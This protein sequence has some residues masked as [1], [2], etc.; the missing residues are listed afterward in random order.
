MNTELLSWPSPTTDPVIPAPQRRAHRAAAAIVITAVALAFADASVVALAIPD[1]YIEFEASIPAVSWVLTG[2]A[3]AVAVA[4]LAL[5]GILRRVTAASLTIVGGFVFAAASLWASL[6]PD[7]GWLIAARVVQGIGGAALIAGALGVLTTLL[8]DARRAARWWAT[9]GIAGAVLGPAVGGAVTQLLDWRAVFVVQAPIAFLAA[10]AA[11]RVRRE[12]TVLHVEHERRPGSAMVADTALGLTFGALVGVLFLGVLLLVVV[13]G[14]PPMAGALV[15]SALPVGTLLA[16]R[17]AQLVAPKAAVVAGAAL[18]AG[19]LLTIAYVPAIEPAWVAA[20]MLLC[21]FGLGMVLHALNPHALPHGSGVRAATLTSTARH[22]GLVVGLALIA[23]VL[24]SQLLDAA[25]VAPLPATKV[26]LDAPIDGP[27]KIRIALDIRDVLDAASK[28][29]VPDLGPVFAENGADDPQVAQLQTDIEEGVQGVITRAFSDS[30]ALAAA[31]AALGG[32]VGVIAISLSSSAAGAPR[33]RGATAVVLG[34]ALA[35]AVLL[36][37]AAVQAASPD[38]GSSAVA[39]PCTAGPDPFPGD[40]LDA[41]IQRLVLSGLNGAA[42]DLGVSR[43]ELVLSLEPRSGVDVKWDRD[44]IAR[45]LEQGVDRAISDAQDRG[46]LPGWVAAAV[47][48]TVD[49][50]PTSWFLEQLGVG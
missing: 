40:G 43:E 2:Y 4:G 33:R 18:L 37:A 23:P 35:A 22:L 47:R 44:T 8:G 15:V 45:A 34:G 42:C 38:F 14:M 1:L 20:A 9:G 13:W 28:G 17:L 11:I 26:M 39:D 6:A 27:T 49:R 50:V 29:E 25:E 30:F 16:P 48:W 24:S 5:L 41:T 36:P 10:F 7:L 19:G 31:L 3:L 21:G 12:A 46:T 32:V